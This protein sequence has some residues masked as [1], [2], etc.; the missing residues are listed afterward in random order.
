MLRALGV[1]L[2]ADSRSLGDVSA[3]LIDETLIINAGTNQAQEWAA[4]EAESKA[5]RR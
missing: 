4:L 2:A 3:R 1:P 5:K